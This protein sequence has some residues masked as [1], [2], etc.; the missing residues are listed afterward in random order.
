MTQATVPND[1]PASS[2]RKQC[3]HDGPKKYICYNS[4]GDPT[5][6]DFIAIE[7]LRNGTRLYDLLVTNPADEPEDVGLGVDCSEEM[8][9]LRML[10]GCK[11]SNERYLRTEEIAEELHELPAVSLPKGAIEIVLK[12]NFY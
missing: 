7:D 4:D 11:N 6:P 2:K 12:V 10:K 3:E 9:W 1:K 8:E 5:G